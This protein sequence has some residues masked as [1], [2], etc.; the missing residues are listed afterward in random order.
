MI[1][2]KLLVPDI[3]EIIILF[4]NKEQF[5]EFRHILKFISW[6]VDWID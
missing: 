3:G 6:E 5:E 4:K 1:A 2:R